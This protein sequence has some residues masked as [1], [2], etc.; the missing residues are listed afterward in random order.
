MYFAFFSGFWLGLSLILAIGA[1]NAFVLRQGLRGEYVFVVCLI[2][3]ASDAIF[4]GAGVSGVGAL[5]E[6]NP[7]IVT[8]LSYGGA[9]FLFV[10]GLRAFYSAFFSI[11]ALVADNPTGRGFGATVATAFVITWAN[12]HVYLDTVVLLGSIAAQFGEHAYVFAS[13]AIVASFTF[14]FGLGYGSRVLRKFFANPRSWRI[15]DVIVGSVM[16]A[17]AFKLLTTSVV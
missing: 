14:F 13:G 6:M 4:I 12:P 3:A 7:K 15:L 5:V 11:D 2:C 1:Q 10:Y 9:A 17:I 8:W 16:W